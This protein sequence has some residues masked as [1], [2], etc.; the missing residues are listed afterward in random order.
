[1]TIQVGPL[2]CWENSDS[3]KTVVGRRKELHS[4][5]L[6]LQVARRASHVVYHSSC[7]VRPGSH[8]IQCAPSA[9]PSAGFRIQKRV[10]R[11][12]IAEERATQDDQIWSAAR[13]A[14][15]DARPVFRRRPTTDDRRPCCERRTTCD[16][17]RSFCQGPTTKDQ[18]PPRLYR[19]LLR[20]QRRH[21]S[22]RAG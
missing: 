6:V 8:A 2:S 21:V 14:T 20:D 19:L 9:K 16:P 3:N 15:Q 11:T 7:V 10:R 5:S 1:M 12:N 18:G 4:M 13:R 22:R 17:R